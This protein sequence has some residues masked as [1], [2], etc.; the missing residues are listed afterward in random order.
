MARFKL[1]ISNPDGRSQAVEVEGARAQSLIG[2]RIGEILDGSIAGLTDFNIQITGGS[3]KAGFPMRSNVHGGVRRAIILSGGV[4]FK[5]S[6]AGQR[7]RKKV[8]GNVIT[9][10]IVQIN[11]KVI[12]S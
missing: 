9:D 3:D 12:K 8:R 4:G 7:R 2:K 5:A 11:F 1:I 6:G 10:E